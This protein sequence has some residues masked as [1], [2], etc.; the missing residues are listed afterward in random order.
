[1]VSSFWKLLALCWSC[2]LLPGDTFRP[3]VL[4]ENVRVDLT[5]ANGYQWQAS[6]PNGSKSRID[7]IGFSLLFPSFVV[8]QSSKLVVSSSFYLVFFFRTFYLGVDSQIY[9]DKL[10]SL[11]ICSSWKF[12]DV[13]SAWIRS[14]RSGLRSRRNLHWFRASWHPSRWSSSLSF[15][16]RELPLDFPQRLELC[17][18]LWRYRLLQM[19]H[20]AD[21]I[22]VDGGWFFGSWSIPFNLKTF[23]IYID[24]YFLFFYFL[25]FVWGGCSWSDRDQ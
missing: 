13:T 16:W 4:A 6:L 8:F 12:V 10:N 3:S 23:Y 22:L 24:V 21:A 14:R 18:G 9:W 19:T 1:M 5:T 20:S 7:E 15:Q 11:F 2:C 17:S 25:F